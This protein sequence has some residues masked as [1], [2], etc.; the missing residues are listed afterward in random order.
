MRLVPTR[1]YAKYASEVHDDFGEVGDTQEYYRREHVDALFAP[2]PRTTKYVVDIDGTIVR[3]PLDYVRC[4]TC[5]H[6][7]PPSDYMDDGVHCCRTN[8]K[9]CSELPAGEIVRVRKAYDALPP[10]TPGTLLLCERLNRM[11]TQR[12]FLV[13]IA[14]RLKD[15]PDD[16]MTTDNGI[17]TNF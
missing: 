4:A 8:C 17:S 6:W 15:V 5:G 1:I 16:G 9:S 2:P 13:R 7:R 12:E 10:A 3:V 14:E 11:V